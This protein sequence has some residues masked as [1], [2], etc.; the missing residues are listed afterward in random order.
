V[1]ACSATRAP[2]VPIALDQAPKIIALPRPVFGIERPDPF[3]DPG[4]ADSVYYWVSRE[5]Q[6]KGYQVVP[7]QFPALG[8]NFG[9]DPLLKATAAELIRYLPEEADVL[10]LIRV[11]H[12]LDFDI[13]PREK[14]VSI[15]LAG[16]AE[17]YAPGHHAAVWRGSAS[18]STYT[19]SSTKV[20]V[21]NISTEFA[22]KLVAPLPNA[23]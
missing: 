1:T 23:P 14:M 6:K 16:D 22:E 9:P 19:R 12:Y 13:C 2:Q 5:L 18:A 10:L 21:F 20:A 3:C 15:E 11:T 4:S 17:L 8:N 7:A